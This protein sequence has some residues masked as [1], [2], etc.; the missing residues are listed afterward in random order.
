[1]YFLHYIQKR[2]MGT[3]VQTNLELVFKG[4][5]YHVKEKSVKQ[6]E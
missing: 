6:S 1:M 2:G 3:L 5:F 4:Y